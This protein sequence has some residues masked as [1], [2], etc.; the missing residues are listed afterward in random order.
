MRAA[1]MFAAGDVRIQDVRD[2][3]IADRTDAVVRVTR[4]CTIK[5]MVR[6]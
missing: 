6:P 4:A 2:A 5:V 1:V 3:A